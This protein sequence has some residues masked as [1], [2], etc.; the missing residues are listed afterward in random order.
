[1]TKR[2]ST[3][4]LLPL[5]LLILV[6]AACSKTPGGVLP[7]DEMAQL[8]ADVYRGESVIEFERNTYSNDSMKKVVKQSV[9]LAHDMTQEDF[10]SSMSWYGRNIEEYVKVCDQAVELLQEESNN[11]P[12]DPTGSNQILVAGDSAQVW[13]LPRFYH[14]TSAT[15]SRYLTFRLSPDDTWEA[16]DE[17]TLQFKLL[18]ARSEVNTAIA[19]DY[20]DNRTEFIRARQD[21]EGWFHNT[22]RLD[23]TR[24]A[25]ALYGYLLFNPA[26]GEN[27]YLDSVSLVRTR[28]NDIR[29]RSR[30]RQNRFDHGY[31]LE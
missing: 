26:E 24:T 10:D 5:L 7:P 18:N 28:V 6:L 30:T 29:Y 8:L 23:S 15:P 16:G 17:Y 25:R 31:D 14:I 12:D 11:I 22:L 13:S 1:M 4:H 9:L 27:I 3:L 21:Q 19:V 2:P 20:D